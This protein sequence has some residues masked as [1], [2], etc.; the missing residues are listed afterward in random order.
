M[1]A[2]SLS[3]M[4]ATCQK[5]IRSGKRTHAVKRSLIYCYS[6]LNG[7]QVPRRLL[8][9]VIKYRLLGMLILYMYTVLYNAV[10]QLGRSYSSLILQGS[11]LKSGY[12]SI[13]RQ[14]G[15]NMGQIN[16]CSLVGYKFFYTLPLALGGNSC[17]VKPPG[18]HCSWTKY[19]KVTMLTSYFHLKSAYVMCISTFFIYLIQS[20]KI[21]LLQL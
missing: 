12:P 19:F 6:T 14:V 2:S 15:W 10:P 20:F 16:T 13:C 3:H 4:Y 18:I 11:N 17:G 9:Y 21:S 8:K 7:S 1:H 5:R